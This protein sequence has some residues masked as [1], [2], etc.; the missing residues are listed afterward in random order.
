MRGWVDG[1]PAVPGTGTEAYLNSSFYFNGGE[2]G[3]PFTQA[4]GIARD[5]PDRFGLQH[6]KVSACRWQVLGDTIDF[7]SSVEFR[8]EIGPGDPSLLDRYRSIAFFYQ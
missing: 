4:W 3:A 7:R 1:E 6:G 8:Y 5:R 2:F